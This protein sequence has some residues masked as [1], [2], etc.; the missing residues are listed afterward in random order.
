MRGHRVAIVFS[1]LCAACR[2]KQAPQPSPEASLPSP[3]LPLTIEQELA[4]K[5]PAVP[6]AR[7]IVK[8]RPDEFSRGGGA[9][10]ETRSYHLAGVDEAR[11]LALIYG[12]ES[13]AAVGDELRTV[14]W[15]HDTTTRLSLH[16]LWSG[17]LGFDKE[18]VNFTTPEA[19]R[20]AIA[21]A[22]AMIAATPP[23]RYG[24]AGIAQDGRALL[25]RQKDDLYRVDIEAAQ[26]SRI[27]T[28]Q[29]VRAFA[30]SPTSDVIA[31]LGLGSDR[32]K[33]TLR[34]LAPTTHGERVVKGV[35]DPAGFTFSSDGAT[36]L[37]SEWA[38]H[39]A[40]FPCVVAVDVA[41]GSS[42][43]LAC[44]K[45]RSFPHLLLSP[46]GSQLALIAFAGPSGD[47]PEA[48]LISLPEGKMKARQTLSW[49]TPTALTNDARL[50]GIPYTSQWGGNGGDVLVESAVD[51]T[52]GAT[53]QANTTRWPAAVVDARL[54]DDAGHVAI[55]MK[56]DHLI[57]LDVA[58]LPPAPPGPL[59]PR[60]D[61]RRE[62]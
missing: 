48:T 7:L 41:S 23:A 29:P 57:E 27:E 42:R 30:L 38:T 4:S 51:A 36:L 10:H 20:E 24:R 15:K 62:K 45:T 54:T 50:I 1:M 32:S 37:V 17:P 19:S 43:S 26:V 11:S 47:D 18:N 55:L 8:F 34:L 9:D 49:F 28:A 31:Y 22:K 46:D 21:Y 25:L 35:K 53:I 39:P 14:D 2:T 6:G 56:R 5:V 44:A 16:T 13:P 40:G 3:P 12:S 33:T 60:V 58:D 59:T 61:P 52:K